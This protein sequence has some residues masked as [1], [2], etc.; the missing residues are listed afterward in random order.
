MIVPSMVPLIVPL[1]VPLIVPWRGRADKSA[2]DS[3]RSNPAGD[4]PAG[5]V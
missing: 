4:N 2:K 3:T 5:L 1:T